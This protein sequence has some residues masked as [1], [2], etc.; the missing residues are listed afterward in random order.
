VRKWRFQPA[1]IDSERVATWMSV[2][3]RFKMDK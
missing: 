3:I 1:R 2:P